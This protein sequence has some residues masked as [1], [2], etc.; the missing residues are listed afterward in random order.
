[1]KK[2]SIIFAKSMSI[3]KI[4]YEVEKNGEYGKSSFSF[5][6]GIVEEKIRTSKFVIVITVFYSCFNNT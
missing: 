3:T 6:A 1:M 4:V 5:V 2:A